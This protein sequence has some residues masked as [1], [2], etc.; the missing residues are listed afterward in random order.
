MHV[1]TKTRLRQAGALVALAAIGVIA[2]LYWRDILPFVGNT[3]EQAYEAA[4]E[5]GE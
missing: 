4:H 2:V 3:A 5:F 1:K